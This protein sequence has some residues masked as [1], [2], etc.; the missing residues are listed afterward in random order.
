M[1]RCTLKLRRP[2]TKNDFTCEKN[3]YNFKEFFLSGKV[4]INKKSCDTRF[5]KNIVQTH[6]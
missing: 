2:Q 5:V 1:I 4:I 6:G 3:D